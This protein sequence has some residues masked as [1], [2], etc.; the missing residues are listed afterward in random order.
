VCGR[1]HSPPATIGTRTRAA[2]EAMDQYKTTQ[3]RTD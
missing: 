3:Q 1:E 2:M